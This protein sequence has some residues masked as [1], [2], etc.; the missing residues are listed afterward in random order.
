VPITVLSEFHWFIFFIPRFTILAIQ[1]IPGAAV[2]FKQWWVVP[3]PEGGKIELRSV[4][5]RLPEGNQVLIKIKAAGINRGELISRPLLVSSNPRAKATPSGIEFAGLIDA[6]GPEVRGWSKGDRVMA[7]ASACHA[8]F[9]LVDAAALMKVPADLT[10]EAAAAIPNV[11]VTAHN[12]LVTEAAVQA[13]E[14]ILITAGSSSV[15]CAAIQI[16]QYLGAKH[17]I[18]TTRSSHKAGA[19]KKLG[20][21][22]VINTTNPNWVEQVKD[23]TAGIN[24]VIDQVGGELFADCLNTMAIKGRFIS[25]GR[26]AGREAKLNLDFLARQRISL[27]GVT[28]RTRSKSEALA[29]STRFASDLLPAFDSGLLQPVLDRTFALDDLALAHRYMKSD[30]QIGKIVLVS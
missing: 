16:A 6:I 15:G 11:Y 17:I 28:F 18:A 30:Q 5:N 27:I 25:V 7:R 19:L 13:N 23:L 26:N 24:V 29:C 3:G 4:E 14:S 20:A 22:E 1:V 8:E 10:L 9:T 2:A 12:A 21:T